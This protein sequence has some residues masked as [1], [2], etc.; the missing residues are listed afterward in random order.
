MAELSKDEIIK[1]VREYVDLNKLE[2][3]RGAVHP[4]GLGGEFLPDY[5]SDE[6]EI[7]RLS[8]DSVT[9]DVYQVRAQVGAGGR[10][11]YRVVDDNHDYQYGIYSVSPESSGK[12]FT[13]HCPF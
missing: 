8:F 5:L 13:F 1:M 10:I 11:R 2:R 3:E 12:P 7:A 6:V 9:W 4:T